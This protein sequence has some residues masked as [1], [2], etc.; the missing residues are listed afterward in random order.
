MPP[1]PPPPTPGYQGCVP[2]CRSGYICRAGQCVSACNPPCGAGERCTDRGECAAAGSSSGSFFPEATSGFP[3]HP[4]GYEE[5]DGF[6]LRLTLGFGGASAKQAGSATSPSPFLPSGD[7][8][9]SGGMGSFGL[10]IG[11]AVTENL[12]IFGRLSDVVLFNPKVEIGNTT[13]T[14]KDTSLAFALFG[15][16]LSY[17]FMP[18]NLYVGGAIGLGAASIHTSG[19]SSDWNSRTGVGLE[20]DAGKEWWVGDDWGLGV[21]LRYSHYDVPPDK[22]DSNHAHLIE[23]SFGVFFTATYN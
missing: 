1:P 15:P 14:L 6:M 13:G 16:G 9:Y 4:P 2:A 20:L 8:T 7:L 21:L 18:I 3:A 19:S 5:H 17:Y 10:D 12:I 23:N 11:A 22:D